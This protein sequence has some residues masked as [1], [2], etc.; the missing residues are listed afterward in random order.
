MFS[1]NNEYTEYPLGANIMIDLE[2]DF[3]S[4]LFEHY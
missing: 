2:T 4:I 1:E 3:G